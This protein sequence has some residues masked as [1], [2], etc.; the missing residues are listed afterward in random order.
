MSQFNDSS[1]G[2]SYGQDF[3][4]S[5]YTMD[6]EGM[7]A[8]Q[9]QNQQSFDPG[10]QQVQWGSSSQAYYPP[11]DPAA[12]SVPVYGYRQQGYSQEQGVCSGYSVLFIAVWVKII[13]GDMNGRIPSSYI[14]SYCVRVS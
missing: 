9:E 1:Y 11:A 13:S 6:A 10:S 7:Q 2:Q 4:Q 5:D 8:Q 14:S 3:Y 12:Q